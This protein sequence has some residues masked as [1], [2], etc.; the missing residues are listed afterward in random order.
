M[1]RIKH[2]YLVVR[3]L[4]PTTSVDIKDCPTGFHFYQP[5]S[6]AL[7]VPLFLRLIRNNIEELFGDYGAGA[8]AGSLSGIL[9]T[10][11]RI[12]PFNREFFFNNE[13][14]LISHVPQTY[15][16]YCFLRRS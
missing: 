10:Y 7:T 5:T 15:H 14:L 2:R 13:Y 1:V 4:Y 3:F 8:V 16:I 9:F 12:F 11:D 6:D